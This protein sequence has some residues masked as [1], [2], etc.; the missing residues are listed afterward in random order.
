MPAKSQR[1]YRMMQMIAHGKGK[2]IGPSEEVAKE[3]IK[4]IPKGKRK[5]FSKK[6]K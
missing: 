4:K 5:I 3:F 6:N 1:Q 2:G